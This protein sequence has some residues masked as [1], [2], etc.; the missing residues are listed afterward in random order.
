MEKQR[1]NILRV[2]YGSF[3]CFCCH[4]LCGYF[5]HGA[6]EMPNM[7][8]TVP[9]GTS[10]R[11]WN[12]LA[13]QTIYWMSRLG[14]LGIDGDFDLIRHDYMRL[15]KILKKTFILYVVTV[16]A[17]YLHHRRHRKYMHVLYIGSNSISK[18]PATID[19]WQVSMT[20]TNVVYFTYFTSLTKRIV[21]SLS[22]PFLFKTYIK[23]IYFYR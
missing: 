20:G 4:I 19:H 17:I 8:F 23:L 2:G 12:D 9:R 5:G 22:S 16:P 15:E 10:V 3:I 14:G 1:V 21:V 6:T 18:L 13:N 7:V 11:H